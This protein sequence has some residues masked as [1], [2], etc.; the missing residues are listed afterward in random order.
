VG[1]VLAVRKEIVENYGLGSRKGRYCLR[2]VKKSLR[3]LSY[4][5]SKEWRDGKEL[6]NTERS[7]QRDS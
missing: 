5:L 4:Y 3:D 1:G 6:W 2:R 7:A